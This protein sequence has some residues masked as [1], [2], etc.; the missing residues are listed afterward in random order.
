MIAKRFTKQLPPVYNDIN[1]GS[2][3]Q[4]VQ[5]ANLLGNRTTC[6]Q[7]LKEPKMSTDTSKYKELMD[8]FARYG[9]SP[10]P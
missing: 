8:R 7:P 3:N 2:K 9:R 5:T 6:K 1:E 4:P 10:R